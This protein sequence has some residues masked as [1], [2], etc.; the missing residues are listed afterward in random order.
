[1]PNTNMFGPLR[2]QDGVSKPHMDS[3]HLVLCSSPL[4]WESL[5]EEMMQEAENAQLGLCV[6]VHFSEQAAGKILFDL[7]LA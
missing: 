2:G 1:M 7:K 6:Q 5:L 4:V 3:I